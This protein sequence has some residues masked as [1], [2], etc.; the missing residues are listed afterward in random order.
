MAAENYVAKLNEYAQRHRYVLRYQEVGSVGPDHIKTFTLRAIVNNKVFPDGVGN[1]KKEAKQNAAQ[2]ALS[3]LLEES[4]DCTENVAEASTSPVHQKSIINNRFVSWLNEYGHRNKVLIRPVESTRLGPNNASYCCSFWVGEKEFPVGYGKTKREAKEEAAKLAHHEICDSKATETGDEKYGGTSIQQN[5]EAKQDVSEICDKTNSLSLKAEGGNFIG[6]VNQYCQE[7]QRSHTFVLEKRCGEAHSPQFFYKL[8]IDNKEYP[9]GK[10]KNGKEAR[11][12]AAQLAWAALQEQ[13]DYDSKV[14]VSDDGAPASLPTLSNSPDAQSKQIQRAESDSGVFSNSPKPPKD[15][16][17]S[18]NVKPKIRLAANFQN[19]QRHSKEAVIY[20][21]TPG[22]SQCKETPAQSVMSRFTLEYDCIECIGKGAFGQVFKAKEKLLDKYCA[23]KIV[24][25]KEKSLR[26]V[27]ALSDL[28]H[29]NIVRYY[30]CWTEDS[31]YQMDSTSDSS[32]GSQSSGNS[33]VKYLYIQM[34]LCDTKTLRVWI[35]E[36]DTQNVK[37]SLR[38]SK[39]REESQTIAKQIV[40]GVDYIHSNMLIHRDLKPANILFGRDRQL[41]I[42]D[43]G[44]VTA[45]NDDDAENLIE[46]TEYKGTPSYMAPEQKSRS[47]YD[48]KVDIF[49]L[50]LIYFELLWNL[51]GERKLIWEDA[52]N[53]KLPQGFPQNFLQESQIIKSMLSLK[54]EDRPEA[55]KL[56]KDIE[57]CTHTFTTPKNMPNKSNT[58]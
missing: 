22:N 50:G 48:R 28:H 19:A 43:F 57:E 13:T 5:E 47:T 14:I 2:K 20:F 39:R 41:K 52:R 17:Q 3:S 10:G 40:S 23:V 6:M 11:Q 9:V 12:N 44:L 55:G 45:E 37:K 30:T 58:V 36:K 16:D 34:E 26:E 53:Q 35:D 1:N 54:P 8:V 21:K 27:G 31:S 33:S 46:R 49:A 29:C 25:C 32:S 38:D 7:T 51:S 24:R 4:T 42:G 15:Q 18:P 56:K